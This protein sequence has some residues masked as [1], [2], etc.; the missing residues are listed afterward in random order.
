ITTLTRLEAQ[1]MLDEYLED[2]SKYD[3][4]KPSAEVTIKG[5]DGTEKNILISGKIDE[6]KTYTYVLLQDSNQVETYY[7]SDL[8]FINYTP[9]K[10]LPDSVTTASIYSVTGFEIIFNGNQD[11]YT[12]NMTDRQLEMNGKAVD[13]ENNEISTAFQNFYNAF[14]I[15]IFTDIDIKASPDNSEPFLTVVYHVNDGSDLKID[16]VDAGNDKCYVF[17]DDVYTGGLIDMNRI[18]GKNSMQS[19][20]N[21]FCER[22]GI[23]KTVQP[24]P[25]DDDE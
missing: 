20:Y 10:F 25:S 13:I 5:L 9:L 3:F 11:S 16:L 17:K 6:N 2:L 24:Q 8:N 18:T 7:I 21:S 23:L 12:L 19:F 15:L 4:D 14:S 1:Q 22:A